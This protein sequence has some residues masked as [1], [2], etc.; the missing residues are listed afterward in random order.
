MPFL[1]EE[2]EE[3][4]ISEVCKLFY[5]GRPLYIKCLHGIIDLVTSKVVEAVAR[6][7]ANG[8]Y[9]ETKTRERQREKDRETTSTTGALALIFIFNGS[10]SSNRIERSS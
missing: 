6:F 7:E 5:S 2:K 8:E 10:Q 1:T 9:Q 4:T 3:T